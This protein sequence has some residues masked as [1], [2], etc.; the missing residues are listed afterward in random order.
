VEALEAIGRM[1]A[2]EPSRPKTVQN[3]DEPFRSENSADCGDFKVSCLSLPLMG[4]NRHHDRA[5]STIREVLG[6]PMKKSHAV[7]ALIFMLAAVSSASA[8][9][10]KRTDSPPESGYSNV[11]STDQTSSASPDPGV[12]L[13]LRGMSAGADRYGAAPLQ[14]AVPTDIQGSPPQS[15]GQPSAPVMYV[16]TDS[17][18]PPESPR[19]RTMVRIPATPVLGV[20]QNDL[21][22]LAHHDIV[23]MIDKSSSMKERD[24][25][26]GMSRWEWCQQQTMNLSRATSSLLSE[27]LSVVLFSTSSHVFTRVS[28]NDV[29]RIFTSYSPGGFTNEAGAVDRVFTD[30]FKRRGEAH[31]KIKPLLIAVITDGLPTD[32]QG[33]RDVIVDATRNVKAGDIKMTFLQ[34]GSDPKGIYFVKEMDQQLVSEGAAFDMVSSK[35]FPELLRSGGLTKAL[36][37]CI[38][39]HGS[40]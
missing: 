6:A 13:P 25:P 20:T 4:W 31:G 40:R 38:T 24:C 21:Q 30:Y 27:G 16:H 1:N 33:L 19:Q 29:P 39:E 35:T 12:G 17:A 23:L 5:S 11:G 9:R 37:D 15:Y 28:I 8:Q 14:S 32:P 36:I 3:A 7:I 34:V 26:G 18:P 10:L 2:D 22:L